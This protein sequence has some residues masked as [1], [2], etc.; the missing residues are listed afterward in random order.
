MLRA[1]QAAKEAEIACALAKEN[2][3][4]VGKVAREWTDLVLDD[5]F[6]P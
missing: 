1:V 6:V 2:A 3:I 5:N 4:K